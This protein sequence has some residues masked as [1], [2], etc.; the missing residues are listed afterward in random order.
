M[1]A[2]CGGGGGGC[3]PKS[4]G[5]QELQRK[6]DSP[7]ATHPPPPPPARRFTP[8]HYCVQRACS[9]D[10]LNFLL[11]HNADLYVKDKYGRTPRQ[12]AEV[13]GLKR[14]VQ[15]L[16][17][18]KEMR[19]L[20][21]NREAVLKAARQ[22]KN[23]LLIE[24]E[25]KRREKEERRRGRSSSGEDGFGDD[26]GGDGGDGEEGSDGSVEPEEEEEWWEDD[27]EKARGYVLMQ[28]LQCKD[29]LS[30]DGFLGGENDTYCVVH[31]NHKLIGRTPVV[32]GLRR[33]GRQSGRERGRRLTCTHTPPPEQYEQAPLAQSVLSL[34]LSLG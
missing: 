25:L 15:R 29:L 24:R 6:P 4:G 30:S 21:G 28:I 1:S 32:V 22:R 31:W 20:S 8:L 33:D 13:L 23:E 26:D 17:D 19:R 12:L 2:G 7:T 18:E 14:L 5:G 9:D 27:E 34:Q 16:K 10:V 11:E 3:K